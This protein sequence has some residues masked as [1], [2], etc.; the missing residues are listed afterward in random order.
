VFDP[1]NDGID[2][3][4]SGSDLCASCSQWLDELGVAA[5]SGVYG[6]EPSPGLLH[7]VWC[8]METDGGGWTL[9]ASSQAAPPTDSAMGWNPDLATLDPGSSHPGVWTGLRPVIP[10]SS[11]LR[12]ACKQYAGTTNFDVDLSFY[13]VGWYREITTGLDAQSCFN[14]NEGFGAD[15]PPERRNNLTGVTLSAGDVYGAGYLE[16]EDACNDTEDFKIDFDDR[17]MDADTSDG[18]DWGEDDNQY[19]CG[20]LFAGQQWFVFVREP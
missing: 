7:D 5:A 8:D 19:K 4:C 17:G 20:V 1:C 12:F 18:T 11:D 9:V 2:Q 15:P 10:A 13:D 14:E 16:G 6:I 3:D